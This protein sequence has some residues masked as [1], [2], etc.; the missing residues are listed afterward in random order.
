MAARIEA[1]SDDDPPARQEPPAV[2]SEHE[3][4]RYLSAAA[5][6]AKYPNEIELVK[7]V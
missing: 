7:A 3:K 1:Q 6:A 5:L 2:S 4:P